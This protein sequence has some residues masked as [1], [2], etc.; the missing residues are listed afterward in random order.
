[1]S[2]VLVYGS[3][4][5]G[6][7]NH[8]CLSGATFINDAT[9]VD[10]TYSMISLGGFPGVIN[11]NKFIQG[12]MYACDTD[13]MRRLDQLEGNGS[14]YTRE[15]VE[16]TEGV[17]WMYMLPTNEYRTRDKHRVVDDSGVESWGA[18]VRGNSYE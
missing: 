15:E 12:E 6:F 2:K 9:T 13:V 1:M 11:G 5:K 18:S 10:S 4:K 16:T 8:G 7:G 17:A 3:L 14:F